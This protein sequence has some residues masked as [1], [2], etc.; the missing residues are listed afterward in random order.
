MIELIENR[1]LKLLK[2]EPDHNKCTFKV[3][4]EQQILDADDNKHCLD[5][6]GHSSVNICKYFCSIN[7]YVDFYERFRYGV[8]K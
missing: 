7:H 3:Y 4:L 6:S 1:L 8:K 2:S 5:C